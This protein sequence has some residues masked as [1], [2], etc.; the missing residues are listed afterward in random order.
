[1]NIWCSLGD[2]AIIESTKLIPGITVEMG[3][4]YSPKTNINWHNVGDV[5]IVQTIQP[6][7]GKI[8]EKWPPYT[9]RN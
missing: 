9:P 7:S 6:K 4:I 8:Q 5:E 2:S 3:P 1:M